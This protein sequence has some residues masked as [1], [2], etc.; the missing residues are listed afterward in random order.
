[1]V[2]TYTTFHGKWFHF[3]ANYTN[4]ELMSVTLLKEEVSQ[5]KEQT[6]P[7]KLAKVSKISKKWAKYELKK[8]SNFRWL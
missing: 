8:I 4:D 6:L 1:M 5:E 7:K 2:S 3:I